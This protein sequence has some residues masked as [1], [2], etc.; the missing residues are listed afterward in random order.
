MRIDTL[1][2]QG[3][4]PEMIPSI[5]AFF[6][7]TKVCSEIFKSCAVIRNGK[8]MRSQDEAQEY[9]QSADRTVVF[10]GI[11]KC[12]LNTQFMTF[13]VGIRIV[14][15]MK[16]IDWEL[17]DYGKGAKTPEK[18]GLK[19]LT[20]GCPQGLMDEIHELLEIYN[21]DEIRKS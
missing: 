11:S 1:E 15:E 4:R 2:F 13:T 5:I 6:T 21:E 10:A 9:H 20:I 17:T 14:Q 18:D 16:I 8:V 12:D 19:T 3:I 7:S